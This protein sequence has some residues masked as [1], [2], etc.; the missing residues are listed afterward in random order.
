M[1]KLILLAVVA[2]SSLY[3]QDIPITETPAIVSEETASKKPF[4]PRKGHFIVNFAFEGMKYE[5]PYEFVG[6]REKFEPRSQEYWGGRVGI[7]SEIYLGGGFNT[8]TK[9]EGYY[10]GTL[11]SRVTNAG[12]TE[13]TEEFAYRKGTG[14]IYG[15]DLAQ[16]IGFLFDMKTKNPFMEEWAYLTVEPFIEAGI[17][18]AYAYNRMNYNYNTGPANIQE[19]FRHRINDDLLNARI[20][21]GINL[22]SSTGYFFFLKATVNKY[23]ITKR[24]SEIHSQP[25][26][27]GA[28][29]R[30][31]NEKS[32]KIDP[33]TIFSLGGGYK[34]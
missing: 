15:V 13:T 25:D 4:N 33:I 23:D 28:D 17:G 7:G 5:L 26:D 19:K 11:F 3:A 24:K 29:I 22:T 34:F 1:I 27:Q 2:S 20:G 12:P 10:L 16:S 8:T 30:T 31:V 18:K 21:G 9:I 32:V 14:H 6:A